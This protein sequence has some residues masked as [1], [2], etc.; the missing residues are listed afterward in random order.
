MQRVIWVGDLTDCFAGR[1]NS[2][3]IL[4]FCPDQTKL[5]SVHQYTSLEKNNEILTPRDN[6]SLIH[7][8]IVWFK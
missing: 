5:K 8:G 2:E 4:L 6:R 3:R 1:D 7:L